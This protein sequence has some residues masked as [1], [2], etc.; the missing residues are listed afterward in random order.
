MSGLP[1]TVEEDIVITGHLFSTVTV[2]L[3]LQV[4]PVCANPKT[5]SRG[6]SV[7]KNDTAPSEL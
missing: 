5:N 7:P 3:L 1:E 6:Q 4:R 2:T